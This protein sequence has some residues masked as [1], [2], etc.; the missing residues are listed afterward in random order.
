MQFLIKL[1]T[2]EG[3]FAFLFCVFLLVYLWESISRERPAP[4][5][6]KT[7]RWLQNGSLYV[8]SFT[9]R[10][11]L[12]PILTL[13]GLKIGL[14]ED[15]GLLPKTHWPIPVVILLSIL[16]LDFWSYLFH[17]LMHKSNWLWNCH[18]VHHSDTDVDLTTAFR[19]HPVESMLN[20]FWRAPM[21][22]ILG[23]P[24]LGLIIQSIVITT[25]G[26][27][28]HAD[29]LINPRLDNRLRYVLITPS[30]HRIHHSNNSIDSNTN[31]GVIF[32]FWD[33]LLG[34]YHAHPVENQKVIQTGLDTG[35]FRSPPGLIRQLMLPFWRHQ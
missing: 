29:V 21:I 8:I 2:L 5:R 22:A 1:S 24:W 18:L 9:L 34:T 31:F 6:P 12:A 30:I 27:L 13:I 16:A 35:S 4:S 26:L 33:R 32:T 25:V 7:V 19:F 15:F 28:S 14:P 10:R 23:V 17:R 3:F 20:A 11:E